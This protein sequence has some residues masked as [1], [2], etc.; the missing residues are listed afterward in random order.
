MHTY[1]GLLLINTCTFSLTQ[2]RIPSYCILLTIIIF[3]HSFTHSLI[4]SLFAVVTIL[5]RLVSKAKMQKQMCA[6][7]HVCHV[8]MYVFDIRFYRIPYVIH[9]VF[10]SYCMRVCHCVLFTVRLH[11][12]PM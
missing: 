12:K 5:A 3:I 11:V 1:V 4:H 9:C 7:Q 6:I 2:W 8:S 10:I